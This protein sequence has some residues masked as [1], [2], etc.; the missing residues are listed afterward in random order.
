MKQHLKQQHPEYRPFVCEVCGYSARTNADL[1]SHTR[2]HTGRTGS[3]CNIC[4]L[5]L[6]SASA[7]SGH[8]R[9]HSGFKPY[10]CT[11]CDRHFRQV[12]TFRIH[13][14][15]IHGHGEKAQVCGI[16]SKHFANRYQ[17]KQHYNTH[18]GQRPYECDRCDKTFTQSSS[19]KLHVRRTHAM[20]L[21]T[22]N[23][24]TMA[25]TDKLGS[26]EQLPSEAL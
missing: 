13:S 9:I 17:L 4:G 24:M 1:K 12:S 23:G 11:H 20:N 8:M 22:D 25:S 16:C 2:V 7:R 10:H 21:D 18:T 5:V 6:S 19:L 26:N 15:R 3:K 14:V